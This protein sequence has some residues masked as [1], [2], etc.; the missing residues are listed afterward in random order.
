MHAEKAGRTAGLFVFGRVQPPMNAMTLRRKFSF[1]IC[2]N[3]RLSAA[4]FC[5][6]A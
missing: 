5:R 3:L 1:L 6:E 4:E 2:V